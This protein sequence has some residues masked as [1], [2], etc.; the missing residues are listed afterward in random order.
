MAEEEIAPSEVAPEAQQEQASRARDDPD[1]STAPSSTQQQTQSC[2]DDDET[3]GVFA[4]R[5]VAAV[6]ITLLLSS[7]A[8][9]VGSAWNNAMQDMAKRKRM[10]LWVYASLMTLAAVMLVISLAFAA[11]AAG[12]DKVVGN[13]GAI[14]QMKPARYNNGD[15]GTPT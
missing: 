9:S 7:L 8:F 11:R 4:A 14:A 13:I 3:T 5:M 6:V 2:Q 12:A 10:P 15:N 1:V